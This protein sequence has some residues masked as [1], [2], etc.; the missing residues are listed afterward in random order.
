MVCPALYIGTCTAPHAASLPIF[1]PCS[2]SSSMSPDVRAARQTSD[3]MT[4]FVTGPEDL[5]VLRATPDRP[6]R[7]RSSALTVKFRAPNAFAHSEC[8]SPSPW[9]PSGVGIRR[10]FSLCSLHMLRC[11][12]LGCCSAFR[13][14]YNRTLRLRCRRTTLRTSRQASSRSFP[15]MNSSVP[16]AGASDPFAAFPK[17]PALDNTFGAL[18]IGCFVGFMCV[19]GRSTRRTRKMLTHIRRQ[20]GWTANQCYTYFRMYPGDRLIL[21][22]LVSMISPLRS[23][24]PLNARPT[25][26]QVAT[27]LYVLYFLLSVPKI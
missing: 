8:N 14:R 18:L 2:R 7:G 21:K 4:F 10:R 20:Y 26:P 5:G 11:A 9:L 1:N 22:S 3:V 25:Q 15:A 27:V 13:C 24:A 6:S 23:Q 16:N 17:I 19:R 12:C